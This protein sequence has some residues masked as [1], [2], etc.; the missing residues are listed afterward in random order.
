MRGSH[1]N[2]PAI[3][4][5]VLAMLLLVFYIVGFCDDTHQVLAVF[6]HKLSLMALQ[7]DDD[8][9]N[10][11]QIAINMLNNEKPFNAL[12]LFYVEKTTFMTVISSSIA[13]LVMML[14]FD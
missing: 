2:L 4:L 11:L 1:G 7:C 6:S 13:Y 14:T 10:K 8:N 3:V 12:G 5:G 9:T